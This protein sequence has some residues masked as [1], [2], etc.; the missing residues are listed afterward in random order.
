M[1]ANIQE[2]KPIGI[3]LTICECKDYDEVMKNNDKNINIS[4]EDEDNE[5]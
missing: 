1:D 3:T 4:E 2:V 5:N